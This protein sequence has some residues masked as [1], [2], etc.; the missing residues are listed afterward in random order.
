MG[1][2]EKN[3]ES[4]GQAFFYFLPV[5]LD[6][7]VTR[8]APWIGAG[9]RVRPGKHLACKPGADQVQTGALFQTRFL[10]RVCAKRVGSKNGGVDFYTP[11][12]TGQKQGRRAE[13][14]SFGENFTSDH[15]QN[16]EVAH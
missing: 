5:C 13:V 3:D 10:K 6:S 16:S 14:I 1:D 9:R 15:V 12:K 2:A 11:S 8:C 4:I 7:G